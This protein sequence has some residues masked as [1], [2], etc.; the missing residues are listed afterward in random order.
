[1]SAAGVETMAA[2]AAKSD[3]QSEWEKTLA[4]ATKEGLQP[5]GRQLS[6]RHWCLSKPSD[7]GRID[8]L[9]ICRTAERL[10]SARIIR[11][12][13]SVKCGLAHPDPSL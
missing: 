7:L 11:C 2:A 4:A 3:W 5:A 8:K 13:V 6:A 12:V 9:S 1:M 10:N